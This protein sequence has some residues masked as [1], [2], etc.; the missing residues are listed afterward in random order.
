MAKKVGLIGCGAI[1]TVLA[2]AIERKVIVCDELVVFDTDAAK[3]QKLKRSLN[4]RV[5]IV[6]SVDE[7]LAA[8]PKVV[9]EAAGQ[10]AVRDYYEKLV[11][12]NAEIIVMSTGAL[13]NLNA[14]DPKVH[15]PAG[16]IGGLDAIAAA[17]NAGIDEVTITSRKNPKALGKSNTEEA[18]IY[19][20]TAKEAARQFPREMNV[21]ATLALMVKPVQ[22]KVKVISDPKVTRNTHEINVKWRYGD[23]TLR[24]ANMPHPDNP[25]TSALAA[26]AAIQLLK[27]LL[28]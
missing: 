16:A 15:F 23:M 20:G 3:A 4:F 22:V 14:D 28:K 5:K 27:T 6:G 18:T 2:D 19:E 1:G 26:W 13:L 25:H 7:L 11:A 8:K 12:S 24:F 21:A 9:V 17:A 10:Q